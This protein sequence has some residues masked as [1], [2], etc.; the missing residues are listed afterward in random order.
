[1]I[2]LRLPRRALAASAAL[3]FPLA[4]A[5]AQGFSFIGDFSAGT[6]ALHVLA[7]TTFTVAPGVAPSYL[8]LVFD[9]ANPTGQGLTLVR[10]F[11]GVQYSINGADFS[12][13]GSFRPN[14]GSSTA[15]VTPNDAFMFFG[16][17][18]QAGDVVV[19]RQG[20]YRGAANASAS[21]AAL[22]GVT[23]SQSFLA[24][25]GFAEPGTLARIS[26][27]VPAVPEPREYVAV[28]AAGLIGFGLW[29]RA[30]RQA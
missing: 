13:D 2:K 29:H 20:S 1:M 14:A 18:V 24:D 21:L 9:E 7:D 5:Y 19:F 12:N 16:S 11:S 26:N 22:E 3:G 8:F 4:A 25:G 23:V 30:Q 28:A 27:V 17:V 6:G 15:D 10:F